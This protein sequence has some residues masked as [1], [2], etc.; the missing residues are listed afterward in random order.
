MIPKLKYLIKSVW[1]RAKGYFL[2]SFFQNSMAAAIPLI[3]ILGIG[4]VVDKLSSGAAKNEI[5]K[6][7]LI[8]VILNLVISVLKII[9]QM[10]EN[11]MMRKS[12]NILQCGYMTD[13]V[14]VDYHFVQNRTLL[15]LKPKSMSARPEFFI[16]LWG[17]SIGSL[18]QIVMTITVMVSL[19]V[20]FIGII[21][22]LSTGVVI[23][24]ILNDRED[25][26][27]RQKKADRDRK[28][29]Y[30]YTTMTDY[31]YAKEIRINAVDKLISEK[32][33]YEAKKQEENISKLIHKKIKIG[34]IGK[35]ILG[36]QLLLVYAFFAYQV[37]IEKNTIAEY[38][39]LVPSVTLAVNAAIS[40]F[41]NLGYIKNNFT[42][43]DYLS[44]YEKIVDENSVA[45]N[46]NSLPSPKV[47]YN[48]GE[49]KFDHVSFSYPGTDKTILE[50]ISFT[51]QAGTKCA[52]VGLNGAGKSTI[53]SLLLRL[54]RPTKGV[55][56][57]DGVDIN[58][59]PYD[60][61]VS[62]FGVVL[63]DFA[64]F[65]YSIKENITFDTDIDD[66][67]LTSVLKD[68]GLEKELGQLNDGINTPLFKDLY[69][70]GIELSGGNGQK[71]A[72]ARALYK[73]SNIVLLDEPTSSFDP[74]AEYDFFKK[75][76]SLSDKKT[77]IFISHRLSSTVF[78][79][80]ILVLSNGII[81]EQGNHHEL[82]ELQGEYTTLFNL[83]AQFYEKGKENERA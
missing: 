27:Y 51:V 38:V 22:F 62:N 34:S 1:R 69:D 72:L 82:M 18:V 78:C 10:A 33:D 11:R 28:L 48:Q 8:Y 32:Y 45:N 25:V 17:R 30:L 35:V 4:M 37:F 24:N 76:E 83:Q 80:K 47:D 73:K 5:I 23:S 77:T 12:T 50:D 58:T 54:Y 67:R 59:I 6:V 2:I 81:K 16:G 64:L 41:S 40:F 15:D 65:A 75:L 14:N 61:Y 63:Q 42:A 70:E 68:S 29:E 43:I 31:K 20:W 55:I 7:I 46:S 66:T 21:L 39:V 53:V 71:L 79:D 49:I 19:N 57:I 74:L 13:C 52:I 3:D 26:K 60:M 36:I 44:Q 9:L 56:Y